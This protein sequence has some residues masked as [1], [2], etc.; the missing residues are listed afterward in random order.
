MKNNNL[1]FK[2]YFSLLLIC[3]ITFII[4]Y[5]LGPKERVGYL[6]NFTFDINRTLELNGLNVGETKKIFTTD[7]KLD[8][9][10]IVNYIFTNEA[11]TNY[12]YGFK[13]G[14]YSK[15]F[16]HSDLYGVYPNTD[17][18]ITDNNFIKKIKMGENGSPFGNLIS[19]K[20]IAVR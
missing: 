4:L 5:I 7:D 15:I 9:D 1:F 14:Y 18:I 17:Q 11:I 8:N 19:R 10:A 6:Y 13:M 2:I 20:K 16:K 12:R 3:I